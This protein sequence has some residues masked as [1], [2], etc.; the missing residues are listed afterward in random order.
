MNHVSLLHLT[1]LHYESPDSNYRDD[2]KAF[3]EPALRA[4]YFRNL[5]RLIKQCFKKTIF[6]AIA[7][8]GDFTTHGRESGFDSFEQQTLPLLSPLVVTP[9]A[10]CMVPGNHDVVWNLDASKPDYFDAKFKRYR[11]CV[12]TS[13]ATSSYIPSG[14]I[15]SNPYGEINFNGSPSPLFVDPAG[16]IAVLCVNSAVRC[17]EVNNA[18]RTALRSPVAQALTEIGRTA[19]VVKNV[20]SEIAL[21]SAISH[22]K[23]MDPLIERYSLFDIPHVTHT[24]LDQ[25]QGVLDD[26]RGKLGPDCIK[27]AI[28]HHH[29]AP[30]D[31]QLA[32]HKAFEV[33]ADASNLLDLLA[34]FGFKVVLTG[35]KHQSYRQLVQSR[36]R[37]ILILGGMTVGGYS[38]TGF[39]PAIRHL[40]LEQSD[41]D[42]R[43][44]AADLPC[45]WDGDISTRV[46]ELLE[47][48]RDS[49]SV[50]PLFRTPLDEPGYS[51]P[52]KL[53]PRRKTSFM[54]EISIRPV[55]FLKW[56]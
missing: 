49:P 6:D 16:R 20:E 32:E 18:I 50:T 25:L 31:Y 40:E 37:D 12:D 53:R 1:D 28:V 35:H 44:R 24:Q 7:I 39:S 8:T 21:N 10:I 51:S 36:G 33:M 15:P 45:S 29:L 22:L 41:G 17:G 11:D 5:H 30:F 27:I 48:A 13:K 54:A 26:Q 4:N 23:R 42:L 2:D 43:V 34:S 56:K 19:A 55:S 52:R 9:S 14:T 47:E 3:L 38:V 46:T